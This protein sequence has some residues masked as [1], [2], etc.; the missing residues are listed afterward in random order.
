MM[1]HK[2]IKAG[3]AA[4]VVWFLALGL[5]LIAG[6]CKGDALQVIDPERATPANITPDVAFAGA[7]S[8]F[9][10]GFSG[11]GGESMVSVSAVFTDE[12]H[13]AGTFPTRNRSDQRHQ[14]SAQDGNTQDNTYDNL[15]IARTSAIA[16]QEK[17]ASDV[18]PGDPRI[19]EL[20]SYIGYVY[21]FMG[22]DWCPYVAFSTV[23]DYSPDTPGQPIGASQMFTAAADTFTAAAS[24]AKDNDRK[25][26]AMVGKARA[27]LD[28]GD[29]DGAAATV[30]SV[31]TSFVF[32]VEHSTASSDDENGIYDLQDNGRYSVSD[33]EGING[34]DYRSADDPR[35][36]WGTDSRGGFTPSI[37]LYFAL[38][39]PTK[40]A[41]VV[42]ADGIEARLIEAEAALSNGQTATWL[43]ILNDLRANVASLMAARYQPPDSYTLAT[44]T[45]HPVAASLAPLADPGT[46]AA[47]VDMM[48]RERA[49]WLYLTGHRLSDMRRLIRQYGRDPESV[50]P[51]GDYF[52]GGGL[53]YSTDVAW[54]MDYQERNN[55]NYDLSQ[56]SVTTP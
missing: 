25:Y 50:F 10:Q 33:V 17:I 24:A 26:L 16:A 55:P 40:S 53:T 3:T 28:N 44:L 31:P 37:P 8:D 2:R 46:T 22:E 1:T 54:Q 12:F 52:K 23:S 27:Q 48:F 35:I 43:S 30:A 51:T 32:Y 42:L 9:Q 39:Y 36:P 29:Y 56:C 11:H 41:N 47:R 45:L 21:T 15:Q 38:R 20:K 4:P 6:A 19:S 34:L 5:P 7:I 14:F 18:S 13:S 49:F